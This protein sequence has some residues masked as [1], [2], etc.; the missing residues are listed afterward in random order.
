MAAFR[1]E[2]HDYHGLF[3]DK[4][5]L[6]EYD[7]IYGGGENQKNSYREALKAKYPNIQT[8]LFPNGLNE[9]PDK[10]KFNK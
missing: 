5:K 2:G 6:P 10:F 7:L 1:S 8:N 9:I 3:G 4:Y